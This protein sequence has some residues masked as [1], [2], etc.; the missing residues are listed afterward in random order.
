MEREDVSNTEYFMAASIA[1]QASTALMLEK[2]RKLDYEQR[3][4]LHKV[5]RADKEVGKCMSRLTPEML[6]NANY[7]ICDDDEYIEAKKKLRQAEEELD[8]FMSKIKSTDEPNPYQAF[9]DQVLSKFC[10]LD[11]GDKMVTPKKRLRK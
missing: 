5:K 10:K 8:S 4:L 9:V 3:Y 6:K 1:M 7:N 11:D 2:H